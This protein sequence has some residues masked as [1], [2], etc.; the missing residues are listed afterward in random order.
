[1]NDSEPLKRASAAARRYLAYRPRS[2]SEVRKRL[3]GRFPPEIVD[4]VINDLVERGLA[5]DAVF[6]EL[7]ADSR[8]RLNPRSASA[9]RRELT[10]KGV[11]R[12]IAE[13]AVRDVD[14][15]DAAYTAGTKHARRLIESDFNTFRSR[16]WGYLLRRGFS[17]SVCRATIDRLWDER[18]EGPS[19]SDSGDSR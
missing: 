11:S 12:D 13:H 18:E 1:M 19:S 15:G 9:I 6:A 4:Y 14:D 3:T 7:W 8:S 5:G 10:S 17:S 2:E 16:L